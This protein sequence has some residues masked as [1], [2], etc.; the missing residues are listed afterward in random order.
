MRKSFFKT[1]FQKHYFEKIKIFLKVQVLLRTNVEFF[2]NK[3][4][5]TYKNISPQ[6]YEEPFYWQF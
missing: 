3:I 4:Q 5:V 1:F 2:S 6:F